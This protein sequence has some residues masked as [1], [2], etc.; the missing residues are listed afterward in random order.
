MGT[1]IKKKEK[2]MNMILDYLTDH[3]D[4]YGIS[5]KIFQNISGTNSRTTFNNYIKLLKEAG[6]TFTETV[7]HAEKFFQL[8]AKPAHS[9]YQSITEDE[10][11]KFLIRKII[12][13]HPQGIMYKSGSDS[14]DNSICG[15]FD[16]KS[17]TS[18]HEKIPIYIE[19]SKL[20]KLIN[21]LVEENIISRHISSGNAYIY[22][23]LYTS[24]ETLH[25]SEESSYRFTGQELTALHQQLS[26]LSHMRDDSAILDTIRQ[27][28]DLV[29]G[30]LPDYAKNQQN[31]ITYGH[32]YTALTKLYETLQLFVPYDYRNHILELTYLDDSTHKHTFFAIAK[33]IYSVEKDRLYILGKSKQDLSVSGMYSYLPADTILSVS[34]TLSQNDEF[35]KSVYDDMF[36]Q[37]LSI[38]ISTPQH[39]RLKIATQ[40][41]ST[42]DK[43]MKLYKARKE[44]ISLPPRNVNTYIHYND[45][46]PDTDTFLH[47]IQSFGRACVIEAPETLKEEMKQNISET[48]NHYRSIKKNEPYFSE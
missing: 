24:A 23:P 18:S 16:I 30:Q 29:L 6:Y 20:R 15:L 2:Y 7:L 28:I 8:D 44:V 39:V 5:V 41:L 37:M 1:N 10:Y 26:L 14:S 35:G 12:Y 31:Y 45:R 27:K 21:E 34:E 9:G 4:G 42:E 47:Y 13:A 19:D 48:L 38:S 40:N 36:R 46:I 17:H 22:K 43:I 3:P 32:Q 25:E 11:Y 33:I